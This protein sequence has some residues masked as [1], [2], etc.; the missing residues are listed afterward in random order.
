VRGF[1][2]KANMFFKKT[3]ILTAIS[4]SL[5]HGTNGAQK[6]MGII[7]MALITAK[8]LPEFNVSKWVILCSA[9]AITLGTVLGGW[10]IIKTVGS[11]YYKI[12][13]IHSF[14]SKLSSSAIIL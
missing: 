3:Q 8:L 11:K 4:L 13:P 12:R 7:T 10:K 14:V 5:S 9:L 1:S 6:T 2:P